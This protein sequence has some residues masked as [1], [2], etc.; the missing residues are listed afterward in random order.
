MIFVN[1]TIEIRTTSVSGLRACIKLK[2]QSGR[3]ERQMDAAGIKA[4]ILTPHPPAA[5]LIKNKSDVE[6]FLPVSTGSFQ[7]SWLTTSCI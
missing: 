5:P 6:D 3:A 1:E 2:P 4:D 7:I